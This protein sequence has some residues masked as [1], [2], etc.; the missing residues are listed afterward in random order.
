MDGIADGRLDAGD[1]SRVDLVDV[2]P[3]HSIRALVVQRRAR[4]ADLAHRAPAVVM[5][6]W[7]RRCRCPCRTSPRDSGIEQREERRRVAQAPM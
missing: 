7:M 6:R 5:T 3:G 1:S 4:R 2:E